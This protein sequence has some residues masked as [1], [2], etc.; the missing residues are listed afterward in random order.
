MPLNWTPGASA[1]IEKV[2]YV[3]VFSP[4][5]FEDNELDVDDDVAAQGRI[6][7]DVLAETIED[8]VPGG[9]TKFTFG[10]HRGMSFAHVMAHNPGYL[11]WGLGQDEPSPTLR[12]FLKWGTEF[13]EPKNGSWE[14]RPEPAQGPEGEQVLA[15][16]QRQAQTKGRTRVSKLSLLVK[17]DEPCVDGCPP[18]ALSRAG[19]NTHQ[20][21]ETC[22]ICGHRNKYVRPKIA[23]KKDPRNCTHENTDSRGSTKKVHKTFC[24]DCQSYI[25]E[26]PQHMWKEKQDVAQSVAASSSRVLDAT[27]R[28]VGEVTMSTDAAKEVIKQFVKIQNRTLVSRSQITSTELISCLQDSIDSH[29]DR[30]IFNCFFSTAFTTSTLETC[31]LYGA[32][33]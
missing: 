13:F 19:S 25:D 10:Q 4:E 15:R 24:K 17:K 31:C 6:D 14:M 29:V 3:G 12:N 27:S 20:I 18:H 16:A 21:I 26:I 5:D 30:C 8:C 23:P 32:E 1:E 22:M 33:R 28:L 7:P 9:K 2:A 11:D